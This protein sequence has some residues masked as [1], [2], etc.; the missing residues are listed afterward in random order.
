[1]GNLIRELTVVLSSQSCV[2]LLLQMGDNLLNG[3]PVCANAS[4]TEL[5]MLN[6]QQVLYDCVWNIQSSLSPP[7]YFS[8]GPE[9]PY[10]PT[11][12]TLSITLNNLIQVDDLTSQITLDYYMKLYWNDSRINLPY[13]FEEEINP[14]LYI[15]GIDIT[16]YVRNANQTT[17]NIWMPDIMIKE[18]TSANVVNEL[19]QL[20]PMGQ[21]FWSRHFQSTFSQPQMNFHRYP[22]DRQN[23]SFTFQSYSLGTNFLMIDL[24]NPSVSLNFAPEQ[25]TYS[26]EENQVWSYSG[27]SSFIVNEKSPTAFNPHRQFSTAFINVAFQRQALGVIIRL[28]LPVTLLLV[29]VG[30]SF[31]GSVEKRVDIAL[32]M[33]L[34]VAALFIVDVGV[35]PFVGY[36]T[37]IDKFTVITFAYLALVVFIH[38]AGEVMRRRT[39]RFPFYLFVNDLIVFCCRLFWIPMVVATYLSSFELYTPATTA[40]LG[41]V[42]ALLAAV[43][44]WR[45]EN[46][47]ESFEESIIRLRIKTGFDPQMNMNPN[48]K[49][50]KDMEEWFPFSTEA[51]QLTPKISTV[52]LSGKIIK[53]KNPLVI[54]QQKRQSI[55]GSKQPKPRQ[56]KLRFSYVHSFHRDSFMD[57]E[58]MKEGNHGPIGPEELQIHT[59]LHVLALLEQQPSWYEIALV[60]WTRFWYSGLPLIVSNENTVSANGQVPRRG[61]FV[62]R[63]SMAS[64]A[65]PSMASVHGAGDSGVV[66]SPEHLQNAVFSNGVRPAVA[67]S[68]SQQSVNDNV[69]HHQFSEKSDPNVVTSTLEMRSLSVGFPRGSAVFDGAASSTVNPII[70]ATGDV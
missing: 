15:N 6:V 21:F 7:S 39:F 41:S 25:N 48:S 32:M 27:Y 65:R 67:R 8:P 12:V 30:F 18:C 55:H 61:S 42:C 59:D 56:P 5:G 3:Y 62:D 46:M 22:L 40:G 11:N 34:V 2:H 35:I 47:G 9:Y 66:E 24:G 54:A 52:D 4:Y 1:M 37:V 28:A 38:F 10:A 43:A 49:K 19:V 45:L 60:W 29:I 57:D 50:V 36:L 23:F 64:V 70:G 33:I 17:L 26:V 14:L 20:H 31:W 69:G 58:S 13:L 16:P 53:P 68:Q 44:Y 63:S 51:I